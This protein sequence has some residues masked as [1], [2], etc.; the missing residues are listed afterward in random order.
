MTVFTWNCYVLVLEL[1]IET[2][3]EISRRILLLDP[4]VYLYIGS[5]RNR[6]GVLSRI[7]R[8]LSRV[9]KPR[10]H[11]D[12]LTLN[13]H[14]EILGFYLVKSECSDCEG[15]ITR[16]LSTSLEYI[17]GFGCSDKPAHKSHLFKCRSPL[18]C[19]SIVY[20]LLEDSRCLVDI[21]YVDS[22]DNNG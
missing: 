3:L 22:V 8:H 6:G 12:K 21:V 18:G 13:P 15:E 10:W 19:N 9:K 2:R 20:S 7:I 1:K 17:P 11:I 5:Y 14:V 16:L 4:G